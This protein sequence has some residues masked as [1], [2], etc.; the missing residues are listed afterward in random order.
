MATAVA[1]AYFN[2]M[3]LGFLWILPL[4]LLTGVVTGMVASLIP[5]GKRADQLAS[6]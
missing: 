1:I 3:N 5:I 2:F 4:S 6:L